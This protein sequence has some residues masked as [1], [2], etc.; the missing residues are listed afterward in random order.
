MPPCR[1]LS[2]S[3]FLLEAHA[4]KARAFLQTLGDG[5]TLD[6]ACAVVFRRTPESLERRLWRWAAATVEAR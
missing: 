4:G 6:V 5:E 3:S 2:W 1:N